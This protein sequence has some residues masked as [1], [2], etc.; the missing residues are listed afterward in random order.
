MALNQ[1]FLLRF[2]H[3]NIMM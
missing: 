2:S 1:H 3:R